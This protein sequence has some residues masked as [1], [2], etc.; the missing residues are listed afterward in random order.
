MAYVL[1]VDDDEDFGLATAT[2][3]RGAGH[4]VAVELSPES[5]LKSMEERCPD[6]AILDVMFPENSS[7]GFE[8]A[9]AMRAR[10]E[11]LKNVPVLLLTGV[12]AQFPLGFGAKDIDNRWL[13]ISDFLEKPI[14]FDVLCN[15]VRDLLAESA[16]DA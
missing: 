6:L 9:R 13:P 12:N 15:K 10:S 1:M 3:L 5:G 7:A 16:A 14:D 2:V 8:L 11:E 4:E